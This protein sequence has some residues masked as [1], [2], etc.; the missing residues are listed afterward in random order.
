[1]KK[2][3]VL[4]GAGAMGQVIVRDLAEFSGYDAIVIADFNLQKANELKNS[5]KS[6][7]LEAPSAISGT[8]LRLL[9]YSKTLSWLLTARPITSTSMS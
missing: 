3:V 7:K 5:L 2:I 4:G 9:K 1:M 6:K 8:Q